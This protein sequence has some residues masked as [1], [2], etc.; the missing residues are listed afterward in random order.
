MHQFRVFDMSASGHRFALHGG[1]GVFHVATSLDEAP[2]VAAVLV[3]G[4]A[5][6]GARTLQDTSSGLPLRVTFEVVSCTLG[7]ALGHLQE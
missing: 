4:P 6:P 7:A 3:G 2:R 1:G 5:A